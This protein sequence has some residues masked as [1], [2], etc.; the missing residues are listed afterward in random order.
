VGLFDK[1]LDVAKSYGLPL[2]KGIPAVVIISIK[3]E[4]LYATREGELA[5]A[6]KMGDTGIY[7]FFKRVTASIGA[8]E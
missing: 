2:E 7:D 4:V 3:N 5:D 8:K 1:N 6:R